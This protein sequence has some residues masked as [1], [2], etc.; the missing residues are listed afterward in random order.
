VANGDATITASDTA[1]ASGSY[2]VHVQG[3]SLV[4]P[5]PEPDHLVGGTISLGD[6]TDA[7]G[8]RV[9]VSAYQGMALGD[10]I[11]LA[12]ITPLGTQKAPVQTV[13]AIG[14]HE[15]FILRSFLQS[16]VDEL[17]PAIA[18]FRYGVTY[19]QNHATSPRKDVTFTA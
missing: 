3:N 11:E 6:V 15:F 9:V 1:G 16:L 12:C 10:V 19:G 14:E 18:G 13:Q 5:P 2:P 17:D 4:L 7:R 8:L